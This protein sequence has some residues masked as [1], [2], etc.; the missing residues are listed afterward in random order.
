MHNRSF[1]LLKISAWVSVST[2]IVSRKVSVSFEIKS[3]KIW[4]QYRKTV[5]GLDNNKIGLTLTRLYFLRFYVSKDFFVAFEKLNLLKRIRTHNL[6][7]PYSTTFTLNNGIMWSANILI[8]WVDN[9]A[10]ISSSEILM[11]T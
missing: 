9:Q 7:I 10:W 2:Q 11:K 4:N 1:D 5:F 8:N 3:H 6:Q